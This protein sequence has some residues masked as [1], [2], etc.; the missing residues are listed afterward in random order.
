MPAFAMMTELAGE[1]GHALTGHREADDLVTDRLH[2]LVRGPIQR[3]RNEIAIEDH[4]Q[5]LVDSDPRQ[6]LLGHR[7]S[8]WPCR[9]CG[10]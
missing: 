5:V 7:A 9:C 8:P 4:V 3:G 6:Q 2:R 10:G 1:V